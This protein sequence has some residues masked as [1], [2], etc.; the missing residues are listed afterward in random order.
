MAFEITVPR[1]GWTM[2]EGTF[3]EWLKPDG[4]EVQAGEQLFTLESDKATEGIEALDSGILRIAPDAPRPGDVVAVGKVLGYLVGLGEAAPFAS[5]GAARAQTTVA[6]PVRV[7]AP[8]RPRGGSQ[9]DFPQPPRVAIS[10]RA[11]RVARELGINWTGLQGTGRAGRIVERDIR[12]A[13][14]SETMAPASQLRRRIADRMLA[15][16]QTTAA[17]TLTT[18]ADA[19]ELRKLRDRFKAEDAGKNRV[20]GYTEL[21]IK[22]TAGVLRQHPLLNAHW[23]Q[24]RLMLSPVVHM[25]LAVDTPAGLMVPVIRDVHS[26]SLDQVAEASRALAERARQ[27]RLRAE[28]M[29]DGTFTI[30]NLG[31]YGIDAFTP[32]LNVPQVAILG[33]GRVV[34]EPAV[35]QGQ[36]VPRDMLTLSLTFDHRAVDGAPAA[37]FLDTLRQTVEQPLAWVLEKSSHPA[38]V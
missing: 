6:E 21:M 14:D 4:A 22:L 26:L 9:A 13:A 12:A 31:R 5:S 7:A 3:G 28:E 33:L 16:A 11:R 24:D 36:L 25:G 27:R 8:A 20:P 2:E 1:L 29:Q 17:V 15:S 19:T 10:P 35:Y 37:R 30:T 34:S 38:F 32:L 23:Q 18:K